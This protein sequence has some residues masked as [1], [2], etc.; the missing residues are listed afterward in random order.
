M[1]KSVTVLSIKV[2]CNH[3]ALLGGFYNGKDKKR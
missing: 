1:L 2:C 3:F